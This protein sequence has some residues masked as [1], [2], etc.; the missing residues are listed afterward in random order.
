VQREQGATS[1]STPERIAALAGVGMGMATALMVASTRGLEELAKLQRRPAWGSLVVVAVVSAG[2]L[3]RPFRRSPFYVT[4]FCAMFPYA[5]ALALINILDLPV[6][7]GRFLYA[8]GYVLSIGALFGRAVWYEHQ[9]RE[10]DL[11]VVKDSAFIAFH[12]MVGAGVLYGIA[13]EFFHAPNLPLTALA[14]F[15]VMAWA[16]ALFVLDRR[17]R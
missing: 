10:L 17:Y 7:R 4:L 12:V 3:I 16:A 2:L 15:G 8:A 1:T 14:V 13:Q 5:G 9:K 11:R 6:D